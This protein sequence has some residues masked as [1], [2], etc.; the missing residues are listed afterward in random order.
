MRASSIGRV[1]NFMEIVTPN[2]NEKLQSKKGPDCVQ[3]KKQREQQQHYY[4]KQ[5]I[6]TALCSGNNI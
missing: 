6:H 4:T 2:N 1:D 3:K 5:N